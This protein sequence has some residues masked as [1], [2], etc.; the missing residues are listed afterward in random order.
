MAIE[1]DVKP[2]KSVIVFK[3]LKKEWEL[4]VKFFSS[5]ETTKL[6]EMYKPV[7]QCDTNVWDFGLQ[8]KGI[9]ETGTGT[10][11]L[12]DCI[13]RVAKS[14]MTIQR[15]KGLGEMNPE[16]LWETTMDPDRRR[17]MQVTIYD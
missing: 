13:I 16:Q 8:N 10:L 2:L 9:Q 14:L 4:P 15:Y 1:G 3:E 17:F 5:E 6:L 12:C 7:E 11:A